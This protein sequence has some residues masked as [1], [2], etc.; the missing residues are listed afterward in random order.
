MLLKNIEIQNF[1]GIKYLSVDLNEVT[2]LIGENNAGK[3]TILDAIRICLTRSLSRKSSP[4][5]E[6][7]YHLEN[8]AQ[9]PSDANQIRIT[10]TFSERHEDEW[11]DELSQRLAEAEQ[12]T[13]D[14]LREITLRVCSRYDTAIGDFSIEYDFLNPNGEPLMK[15]KG[16]KYLINLQQSA[17]TFYLASLRDAAAEFK[18]RSTFWAPFLKNVDLSVE[19]EEELKEALEQINRKILENHTGFT[20]VKKTLRQTAQLLPLDNT[21][22]VAI[23]A[24]PSK[25]FD[26]LSR[27][28]VQLASKTGAH[29]PITRH[30]SGTQSLAVMCLFDAFL[31]NQLPEN[32]PT[33]AEPLLTLEEPEAHLHPSAVK[34]VATMLTSLSGQKIISTHSG[35][36]LAG[37]QLKD[38]RRLRRNGQNINIHKL[39]EASLNPDEITKLDYH[40]RTTRGGLLFSRCWIL[41][42]GETEAS[43]LSECADVMG[44]DLYAEG[45]S[46]IQYSQVGIEKFI[47]LADQLG[48]E[49]VMLS[50]GDGEGV[51]YYQRARELLNGKRE[52]RHCHQLANDNMEIYLCVEGFG[53]VYES[54]VADQKRDKITADHGTMDYWKQVCDAQQRNSK[55][56]NSLAVAETLRSLGEDSIPATLRDLI[57]QA[58]TLSGEAR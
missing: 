45:V 31:K 4:F 18:A 30:G 15:A 5:D 7:D 48:I 54:T 57:D 16:P 49:W 40:I 58:L 39:D 44:Y 26:I 14:G 56:R 27:T 2:V 29:I 10:L 43:L 51:K 34:S 35:D 33:Q 21:D 12:I 17:P 52:D 36:L 47:K 24:V 55:P 53:E 23:E 19:T 42:E 46:C 20:E 11:P 50:D 6:Y 1:R 28:Q 3:S 41:V 13:T 32:S 9:S 25:I 37:V 8:N 22:P 38:I